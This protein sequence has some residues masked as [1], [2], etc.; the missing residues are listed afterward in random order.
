MRMPPR[1]LFVCT[2]NAGRSQI[3]AALCERLAGTSAVCL[4]AGVQPWD[5]LHPMAARL[6]S[7]R[8]VSLAGRFPKPVSAT[9]TQVIDV[10][11]TIGD[12][13]KNLLPRPM[14]GE[15][16]ILHWD[17]SD[18]ADADGTDQSE[19]VFRRTMAAI[20]ARLPELLATTHRMTQRSRVM[21]RPGITTG[22]W[23]PNAFVPAV[24]LPQAVA[25][26]FTAIEFNLFLGPSHYDHKNPEKIRELKRIADDL[27]IEIWSIHE[28]NNAACVGSVNPEGRQAA[29]DDLRHSLELAAI[30]GAKA[31]PSHALVHP[32]YENPVRAQRSIAHDTLLAL[33]PEILASGAKVAIENGFPDTTSVIEAFPALP[34]EAFGFVIDTGH[35]NIAGGDRDQQR[36]FEAVGN[37]MVSLHLND[38]NG[39]SDS[40]HA[41]G[42]GTVTWQPIAA[43]LRDAGYDGCI[44]WEVFSGLGRKEDPVE[45]MNRTMAASRELFPRAAQG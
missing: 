25:A 24:H 35:A 21:G 7:E 33:V 11:V 16:L 8:G 27:G 12:P 37:R 32:G 40:H 36:I 14:P 43:Q 18:P 17:I 13:A 26:G 9:L 31:I 29:I 23:Y 22:I 44:L 3:A 41:P 38:N 6:L 28:P 45:V 39:K 1:I 34:A 42:A 30:L 19:P 2:G 20:E 5:N 4:S 10:V 15:P